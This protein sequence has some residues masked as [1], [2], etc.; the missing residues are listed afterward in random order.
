[1]T[2]QML[3]IKDPVHTLGVGGGQNCDQELLDISQGKKVAY[4][5]APIGLTAIYWS[6]SERC[7]ETGL[8]YRGR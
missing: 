2:N 5:I 4:K 3:I 1:M 6:N 8:T 7:W